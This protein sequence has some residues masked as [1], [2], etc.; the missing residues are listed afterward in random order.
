MLVGR[1]SSS[2]G[3][4][5]ICLD[6]KCGNGAESPSVRPA[7][8][9]APCH[10]HCSR[11]RDTQV[12]KNQ[13]LQRQQGGS[14]AQKCLGSSEHLAPIFPC[15]LQPLVQSTRTM[16][17]CHTPAQDTFPLY[18]QQVHGVWVNRYHGIKAW[19]ELEGPLKTISFQPV[20][21]RDASH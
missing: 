1:G 2:P 21:D 6:E 8:C 9:T 19:F 18:L 4:R 5:H 17:I 3:T 7:S 12:G 14:P 16:H 20:M 15:W 11:G 10:S 13:L